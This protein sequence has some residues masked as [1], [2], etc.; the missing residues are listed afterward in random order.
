MWIWSIIGLTAIIVAVT[1]YLIYVF[2]KCLISHK[3]LIK[4][5]RGEFIPANTGIIFPFVLLNTFLFMSVFF[6]IDF[7]AV[8]LL[9]GL[10]SFFAIFGLLDDLN[11]DRQKG[12]FG[13]IYLFIFKGIVSSGLVKACLGIIT[14]AFFSLAFNRNWDIHILVDTLIIALTANLINLL[15]VRPGRAAKG[16]V[17]L[18]F[19]LLF[20]QFNYEMFVIIYPVLIM[21]TVYISGDI[22]E[23]FMMGDVGANA[24]GSFVG[25]I[26]VIFLSFKLKI[27]F[28]LFLIFFH[29]LTE[30]VPFSKIIEKS[31]M[32]SAI[33]KLGRYK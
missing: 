26:S 32:L 22:K 30:Y 12:L 27:L 5:Y 19:G 23:K 10:K 8:V 16:I 7:D 29:I 33:D 11:S 13:H 6:T 25:G 17:F 20:I 1:K 15:D 21:I 4:N 18:S 2:T 28:L 14:S 31:K 3:L 24:I 9:L